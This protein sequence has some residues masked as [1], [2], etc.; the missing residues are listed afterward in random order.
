MFAVI[1]TGGKQ[2]RVTPNAV[3]KVEKL[4]A[5]VLE[6]DRAEFDDLALRVPQIQRA[7]TR[8]LAQRLLRLTSIARNREFVPAAISPVVCSRVPEG[9]SPAATA[10]SCCYMSAP[11]LTAVALAH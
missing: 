5:E 4:D 10:A 8:A 3:L 7:V 1:R 2:Y 6:I 9:Y 11:A